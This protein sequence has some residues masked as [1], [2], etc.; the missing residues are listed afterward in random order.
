MAIYSVDVRD[1]VIQRVTPE[2]RKVNNKRF[3]LIEAGSTKQAW[4]KANPA[5][6]TIGSDVCSSCRHHHC[7]DCE[8]WSVTKRYS[9]Y[10]ICHSCGELSRR[11]PNLHLKGASNGL[12]KN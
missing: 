10:W 5:P 2:Y 1:G 3:F 4:A 12:G 9:D 7:S 8:T 11:V 6:K